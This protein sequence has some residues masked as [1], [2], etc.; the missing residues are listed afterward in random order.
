MQTLKE[1][2]TQKIKKTQVC[3][4]FVFLNVSNKMTMMQ[5]RYASNM[6]WSGVGSLALAGLSLLKV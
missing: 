6:Q 1:E 2:K 3:S 4:L 5:F